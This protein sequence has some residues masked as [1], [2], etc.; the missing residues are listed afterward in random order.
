MK[1]EAKKVGLG[2]GWELC[3]QKGGGSKEGVAE[4]Q[5]QRA[6]EDKQTWKRDRKRLYLGGNH[7]GV[8]A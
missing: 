5:G 8:A 4:E 3:L 1:T 6:S 7:F 2:G